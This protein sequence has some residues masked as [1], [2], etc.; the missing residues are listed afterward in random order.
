MATLYITEYGL[1]GKDRASSTVPAAA[2]PELAV[3]TVSL[4][5]S[6]AAS[7]ALNAQTALIRLQSDLDCFVTFGASPTA[8]TSKTP[9]AANT[10]EYFCVTP[11]TSVKV[12][13]ITA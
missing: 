10:P 3:Q 9:L 2:V 7:S 12:A 6:S 1:I 5:T 4:S 8:S 11:N 13:A